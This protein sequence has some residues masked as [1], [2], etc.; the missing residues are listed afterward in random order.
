MGELPDHP[1]EMR[2]VPS[3]VWMKRLAPGAAAVVAIGTCARWG[4]APAAYGNPTAAMSVQDYLGGDYRRRHDEGSETLSCVVQERYCG[5]DDNRTLFE[6]GIENATDGGLSPLL[7]RFT[8]ALPYL[9]LI[10]RAKGIADPFDPRVVEAYWIGNQLLDGVEVR[11][12]YSRPIS[13]ATPGIISRW[14]IKRCN[15]AGQEQT[16]RGH[17]LL[18]LIAALLRGPVIATAFA[19]DGLARASDPAHLFHRVQ[20]RV[21][22]AR[23]Y[24]VTSRCEIL[25]QLDA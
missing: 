15:D 12:L 22:R 3:A 24:L 1:G 23:A 18:Q 14:L 20:K 16:Q 4:G 6:Y 19:L 13:P 7:R 9:Q 21:Q 8:G 10:A 5:C 2:Q 11:Q 25:T 17:R